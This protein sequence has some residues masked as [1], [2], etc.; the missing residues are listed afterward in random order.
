MPTIKKFEQIQAWQK[1]RELTRKVY[2]LTSQGLM[3][4]DVGL[5][6]QLRRACVSVMANIAEGFGR[7]SDREFASFLSIAR[8]SVSEAQ[9]HVY[10]AK[11]LCYLSQ[12]HFDELYTG[13][14]EVGRM[15]FALERHL[16]RN[17]KKA[18]KL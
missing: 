7:Y 6:N 18:K 15:T 13:L 1:A 5:R 2:G 9:S 4:R 17:G 14:D 12:E 10:V 11:D 3:Q 8:G 16:R